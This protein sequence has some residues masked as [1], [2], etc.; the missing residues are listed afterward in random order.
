MGQESSRRIWDREGAHSFT[1]DDLQGIVREIDMRLNG[2][3][4]Y[5]DL[6]RTSGLITNISYYAE[7]LRTTLIMQRNITYSGGL[8]II[9]ESIYYNADNSEDCRITE[10]VVRDIDGNV[11]ECDSVFTTTEDTGCD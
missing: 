11:T 4:V 2:A 7:A 8:I 10:T 3:N 5:T 9:I 6:T 1:S